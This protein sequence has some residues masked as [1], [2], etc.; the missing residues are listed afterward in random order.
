DQLNLFAMY[1]FNA[2]ATVVPFRPLGRQ[3]NEAVLDNISPNVS[4]AGGWSDSSATSY[5]YGSAGQVPYR[6]AS[7]AATETATATYTPNIPVAGI[8][9]VYTWVR[10]GPDRCDQLYRIRHS[11]G[12]G[13]VR[14]PHHMVGNGWV[15]L[16]EYHFNAGSNAAN[17]SVVISNLR[18]STNGSVIIA[19]A[20][21]FGNGMGSIDRG[22]GVSGY[23]REEEC[24]RYWAAAG[25]GYG[26][27]SSLYDAGSHDESDSWSTPSQMSA[28][29]NR[30]PTQ[31]PNSTNVADH[32]DYKRIHISFHSNAATNTA[33]G[34]LALITND[35]TPNQSALA[36]I[37]GDEVESDLISVGS[38]PL[39]HPWATRSPTYT[40][41]Y[42]EIDGSL[43]NYEMDATIIEVAFHSNVEDANLM[44][45]PKARN[46][47]AR[48][49]YHGVIK[50]MNQF[51]TN[52]VVPLTFLPEP[53]RSPRAVGTTNGIVLSW[54]API[55]Q[56]GSSSPTNYVIYSSTNGYGF[57]NIVSVG[58][59]LTYTFTNLATDT[60]FYF[61]VVAAN[62]AGQS[63]PAE[64]VGCRRSSTNGAPKVLVVNAFDRFDR[65]QNLLQ[66]TVALNY[67][68]P[69]NSGTIE[70][71]NPR[72]NNSFDYVVP[73]GKA[74]SAYGVAFDSCQ[75][76]AI[77]GGQ[78]VMTNY[79]M[80]IWACGDESTSDETFSSTEQTKVITFLNGGGH[81]F[82]S[83]SEIGWDL[84]R[85]SGPTAADRTF[86]NNQLHAK[87][88][89]DTND[90]SGIYT[91]AAV[92]GA[93]FAGNSSA[94]YDDG[95]KGI[96][97]VKTPDITTPFGGGTKVALYYNGTTNPAGIQYDGS[98][99][100][101]RVVY[102]GFPFE[103]MTLE[104]RRIA[105]MADILTFF[106][107]PLITTQ[108]I[109]Q[110]VNQGTNVTFSAIVSGSTPLVF[111]WRLNGTNIFG[112]TSTSLLFSNVQATNAGNYTLVVTNTSGSVTSLIA[113]L[114]VN[115][116]PTITLQP[117]DQSV[118]LGQDATFV[119][120]ATGT[121][122]LRYQW[123]FNGT[124]ILGAVTNV[125][126]R[127]NSQQADGGS[128]Q[129]LVINIAGSLLSSSAVLTVSI[130]A[131]AVL[132]S[133]SGS[134][135]N[136]QFVLTGDSGA[137]YTILRSTNL[138]DWLPLTNVVLTNG[139]YQF[140]EAP[141][142][143]EQQFYRAVAP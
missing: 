77:S 105:Y 124:N 47:I 126:T 56:S 5:F 35:P 65:T 108:P 67:S 129:V 69:D 40:G 114:T 102:W 86:Y 64:V 74:I 8:Y 37:C 135:S 139:S 10:H 85:A 138:I 137:S 98:L 103:T 141:L 26:M 54:V 49:A 16:G 31:P 133:V 107:S 57:G 1:C 59:V 61:R 29:M 4:F 71:V 32:L 12:E 120:Q 13:Q 46:A 100:G 50:Y 6:Y 125:F 43:F 66:S 97:W 81:L 96:Y 68:P 70:R 132:T 83:G 11:G 109:S 75:N 55:N 51:D 112:A 36:T 94:V 18:G 142:L 116:P 143:E 128:Y 19:D 15:Y 140:M 21:R 30:G 28:E 90:N 34:T 131:P 93:I 104:A 95:S 99:G 44:R 76:E 58:N 113:T 23:P 101:G 84:D 136:F 92:S 27:P 79:P 42:S 33:R 22:G 7:L 63:F 39:E 87:F 45:D 3:T 127:S 130:P 17:G 117:L 52:D 14:V 122:P 111:Q 25:I 38:P 121:S 119:V 62:A 80:A 82:V 20:I 48:A 118:W 41:G 24:T 115:L 123:Q 110:I 134:S 88:Y 60:D 2:G 91:A 72:Q 106:T 89:S 73:H 78:I 9:P 53:P